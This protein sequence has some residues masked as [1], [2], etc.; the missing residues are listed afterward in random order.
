LIRD[1]IWDFDGTLFDT[2][3]ATV[4]SFQRA[5]KDNGIDENNENIL[6]YL[7]ISERCAVSHFM[8]LYGL[9]DD[10]I[11]KFKLHKKD[12]E[13]ERVRPFPYA[14]E[15]CKKLVTL[16]GRNYIIT[17]RGDSTLQFL[18]YHGMQDYFTEIITKKYGFSR[19]PD[20][21]AFLYLIEKYRIERSSALVIGDRECEILAAKAAG[22][23][24][25]LYNTN[26][27]EFTEIPDFNI[28]S[29]QTVI[30]LFG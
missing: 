15:V 7:K 5:L 12:I 11:D 22:I 14:L 26:N 13:P 20:P 19:K 10:F 3:P 30:D 29:L 23:K 28:H 25:C 8:E 21:E 6:S 4:N 17:H 1:V 27:V 2:Y 9:N 16:G 18:Q 24:V